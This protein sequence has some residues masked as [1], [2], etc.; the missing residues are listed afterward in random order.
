MIGELVGL[1]VKGYVI[2]QTSSKIGGL[3]L[4]FRNM[5]PN[6]FRIL[7]LLLLLLSP[8]PNLLC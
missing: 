2:K 4:S 6:C 1:K 5:A 8:P 3:W 7:L